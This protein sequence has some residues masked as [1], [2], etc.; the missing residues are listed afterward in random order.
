MEIYQKKKE[1]EKKEQTESD[2]NIHNLCEQTK[3]LKKM[4]LFQILLLS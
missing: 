4:N 1:K 2:E 3:W